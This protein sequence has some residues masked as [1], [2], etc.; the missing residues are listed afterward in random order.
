MPERRTKETEQGSSQN[1]RAM[2]LYQL[3]HIYIFIFTS[4]TAM[5]IDVGL[6]VCLAHNMC[7]HGALIDLVHCDH[8]H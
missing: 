6:P 8:E 7:A 4:S 5:F 2:A 3:D 1:I